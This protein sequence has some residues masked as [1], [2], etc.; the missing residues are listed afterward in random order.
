M[1]ARRLSRAYRLD[2][3]ARVIAAVVGGYGVATSVAIAGAWL[4]PLAPI[5]AATLSTI[6]AILVIP[7]TV[8][9]CFWARNAGRAWAGVLIAASLFVAAAWLGGWRP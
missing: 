7:V 9:G 3:A 1:A 2:V 6:T 8:M 4:L 5:D